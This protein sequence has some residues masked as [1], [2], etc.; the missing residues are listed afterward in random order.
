MVGVKV[1]GRGQGARELAT[2]GGGGKSS[3]A[4]EYPRVL[5]T[6]QVLIFFV[7]YDSD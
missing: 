7:L 2:C 5:R 4:F 3:A 1:G 6:H